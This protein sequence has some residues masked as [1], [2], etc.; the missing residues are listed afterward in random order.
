MIP[1]LVFHALA[2]GY[3]IDL[4]GHSTN[5]CSEDDIANVLRQEDVVTLCSPDGVHIEVHRC[6]GK[7][8]FTYFGTGKIL[9]NKSAIA[10]GGV[11]LNIPHI[12]DLF[13][14]ICYHHTGHYWSRLH[15]LAD[16]DGMVCHPSF[17]ETQA[18]ASA[19]EYNLY[20]TVEACLALNRLSSHVDSWESDALPTPGGS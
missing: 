8:G 17:N 13:P 1:E 9:R 3:T 16:L 4:T 11:S 20:E 12:N 18:L 5:R 14:Y 10:I 15:W 19:K 7:D 2:S 6:L